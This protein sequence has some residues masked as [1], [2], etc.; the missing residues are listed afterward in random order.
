MNKEKNAGTNEEEKIEEEMS[1]RHES[2][3]EEAM[4]EKY[5]HEYHSLP[6]GTVA[7]L[8]FPIQQPERTAPMKNISPSVLPRFHGKVAKDQMN[9]FSSLI[10]SVAAMTTSPM[11]KS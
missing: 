6:E 1:N 4:G 8:Q 3:K 9:F 11:H 2:N 10:S 7:T 5:H